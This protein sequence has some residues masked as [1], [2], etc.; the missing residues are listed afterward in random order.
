MTDH[1]SDGL[2]TQLR[3]LVELLDG[4]LET[5]YRAEHPYYVPRYTPVMKALSTGEPLSIKAIAEQSS[6]SHSA[7][8]QTVT[9]LKGHGLVKLSPDADRRSRKVTLTEAGRDLLPWLETRWR[10]TTRAAE[11]LDGELTVPL[12]QV[13]AEAISRLEDTGFA[14]RIAAFTQNA[15]PASP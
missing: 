4:E 10:A 9:R 11:A 14:D 2:G 13:L 15:E 1:S 3:R 7:A 5:L 8:S 12:S 6:V